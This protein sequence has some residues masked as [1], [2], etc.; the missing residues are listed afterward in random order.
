MTQTR[1]RLAA[2]AAAVTVLALPAVALAV[3]GPLMYRGCIANNDD[4]GCERPPHNSLGN[5][6]S[7]ATS[8]DG[9]SVYVAAVEGTLTRLTTDIT[10]DLVYDTCFAHE[11]RHGSRGGVFAQRSCSYFS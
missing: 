1:P 9:S 5:N 2:L 7:L 3:G 4:D 10:G 6:V 11:S 8:A